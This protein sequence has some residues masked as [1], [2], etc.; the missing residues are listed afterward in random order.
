MGTK[1]TDTLNHEIKAADD[2]E[3]FLARNKGE[4]LSKSLPEHL[5]ILL[6]QKAVTRADVVRG[7]LLDRAYL[8][9]I[10]AG[11]KIPSRDKLIAVAFG[12]GLTLDETQAMLKLSVNRELYPRDERDALIMFTLERNGD[13]HAANDLLHRH[14]FDPLGAA[15]LE[16]TH[17]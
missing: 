15:R 4:L 6:E 11:E 7:S 16:A 5:A 1:T 12:L 14:G 10:F 8:Y 17:R 3:G 13:I 2:V 9:Q